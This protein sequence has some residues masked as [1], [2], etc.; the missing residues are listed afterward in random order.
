MGG[1]VPLSEKPLTKAEELE[2]SARGDW[3]LGGL[4]KVRPPGPFPLRCSLTLS[5]P[6][7]SHPQAQVLVFMGHHSGWRARSQP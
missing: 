1:E 2:D 7:P 3:E 6:P 5:P 4:M